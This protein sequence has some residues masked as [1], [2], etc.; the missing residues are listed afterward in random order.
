MVSCMEE[1]AE[2]QLLGLKFR[3]V[4]FD[5]FRV[6]SRFGIVVDTIASR[7]VVSFPDAPYWRWRVH[8][9]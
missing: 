8:S 7:P 5:I 6:V 2:V 4:G 1:R 3:T 9:L